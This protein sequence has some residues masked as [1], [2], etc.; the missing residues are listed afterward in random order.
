[1]NR[2]E[3]IKN[4]DA[5]QHFLAIRLAGILGVMGIG[6]FALIAVRDRLNLGD[7][8]LP[9]WANPAAALPLFALS[10][11]AL[12]LVEKARRRRFHLDCGRCGK[13]LSMVSPTVVATGRCGHC[14]ATVL[15][16]ALEPVAS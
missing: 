9:W 16:P 7:A 5:S 15:D 2:A 13:D 10:L 11:F 12:V 4:R 3:F 1:M 8:D 14:G 6:L